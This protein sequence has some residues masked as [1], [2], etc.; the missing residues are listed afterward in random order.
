MLRS[1]LS[2]IALTLPLTALANDWLT[3]SEPDTCDVLFEELEAGPQGDGIIDELLDDDCINEF[4]WHCDHS[5]QHCVFI[6]E[7][8]GECQTYC[9]PDGYC[10]TYCQ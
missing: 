1:A 7:F 10:Y 2:I 4:D 3:A 6:F 5:S 9:L 8:G